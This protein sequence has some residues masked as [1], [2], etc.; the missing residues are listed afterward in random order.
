MIW[1]IVISLLV[2]WLLIFDSTGAVGSLLHVL[3][4]AAVV[5]LVVQI[6]RGKQV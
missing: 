1:T 6:L 3:L 5:V 4:L 2:A